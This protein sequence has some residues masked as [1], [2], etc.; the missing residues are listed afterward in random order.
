M[1]TSIGK[2]IDWL[3]TTLPTPLQTADPLAQV[4]DGWPRDLDQSDVVIGAEAPHM[5]LVTDGRQSQLELGMGSTDEEYVIPCWAGA[6]REGMSLKDARDAAITLFDVVAHTIAG[7]RTLG[8][9]LLGGRYAYIEKVVLT[10][11]ERQNGA[12][13]LHECVLAFEVRCTNHYQ[14]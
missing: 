9:A 6:R 2:A 14:P 3:V 11:D 10:Q 13:M 5:P 4:W 7:D 12:S 8:G 1:G